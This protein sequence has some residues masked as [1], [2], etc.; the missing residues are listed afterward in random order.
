MLPS[1]TTQ[2]AAHAASPRTIHDLRVTRL[3]A[4]LFPLLP[5]IAAIL[6][7]ESLAP[8]A[9][10]RAADLVPPPNIRRLGYEEPLM[11]WVPSGRSFFRCS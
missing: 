3:L 10:A 7:V 2:T 6:P 11:G 8:G 5:P 4:D 9:G 1:P